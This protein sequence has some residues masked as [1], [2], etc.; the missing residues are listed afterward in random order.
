MIPRPG[1]PVK[2]RSHTLKGYQSCR[3]KSCVVL[4][5][6][7]PS[8]LGLLMGNPYVASSRHGDGRGSLL[9]M[10]GHFD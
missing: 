10:L 5:L 6:A 3:T 7:M 1:N 9:I 8:K 4:G 2:K